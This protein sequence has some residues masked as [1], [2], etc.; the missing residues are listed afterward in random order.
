V[1]IA[2][3]K[4]VVVSTR[5]VAGE[6]ETTRARVIALSD[7]RLGFW[8]VGEIK[9]GQAVA[10]RPERSDAPEVRG[11]AE[12]VRSGRWFDEVVGKARRKYGLRARV[13]HIDTVVLVRLEA[14]S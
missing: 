7:G 14:R 1:E 2:D 8:M 10:V 13:G 11:T 6:P 5:P 12:V 4:Y 9:D 3:E